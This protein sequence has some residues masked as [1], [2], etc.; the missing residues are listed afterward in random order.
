MKP[1]VAMLAYACDPEGSGEHWLGWGWAEQAA[2]AF[3]VHLF[4]PAKARAAIERRSGEFGIVAHLIELPSWLR[5]CS[6]RLGALGLWWRK[7]AW[8]KRVARAV[9]KAHERTPFA[10]VHHT[11]FHSFRAPF[12]AASL[13]IP[14]VWGPIAGG[15]RTPPGFERFLG[16]ARWSER[17]RTIINRLWLGAP[18]VQRALRDTKILFVSNT[19]TLGFLPP[20]Y[21]EKCQIVPPNALRPEDDAKAPDRAERRSGTLTLL[22]VGN[23]VATRSIPLVLLAMRKSATACRLIVVGGGPALSDWRRRASALGL[24]ERVEFRGQLART[25]LPAIYACADALVFPAL[26]DSGG[27][28]LLEAMSKGLPVICLDWAGPGEM[29]DDQ[30]GVKVSAASPEAAIDGFAAAFQRL[31]DDPEW[32]EKMGRAA[33]ERA[34]AEFSWAAKRRALETAY[35]R[36]IKLA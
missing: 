12:Y 15:E 3:E 19:T 27:S 34:H 13:E 6:E 16:S 29:V 35:R 26:R 1:R 18:A 30:S 33:A 9:A 2:G 20:E 7:I 24:T 10:L 21:R 14:A 25:D 28:A 32:K 11:T 36:L 23:C 4:T 5:F 22:Y 8:G 17:G 31:Q